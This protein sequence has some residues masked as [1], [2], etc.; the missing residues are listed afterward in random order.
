MHVED[1]YRATHCSAIVHIPLLFQ[2]RN[3]ILKSDNLTLSQLF[4]LNKREFVALS[5]LRGVVKS[6]TL[7]GQ[8]CAETGN[9]RS[10]GNELQS[11]A[12]L[13]MSIANDGSLAML[14]LA[15]GVNSPCL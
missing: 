9:R 13:R 11:E 2:N 8:S 7:D 6:E 14:L 4:H 15:L 1:K 5:V 12:D 3:V 10:Y